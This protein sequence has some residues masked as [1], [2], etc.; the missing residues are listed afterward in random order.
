MSQKSHDPVDRVPFIH[1][2]D[3]RTRDEPMGQ[4]QLLQGY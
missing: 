1:S 2:V 4:S 3:T